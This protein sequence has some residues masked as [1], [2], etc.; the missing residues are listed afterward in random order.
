MFNYADYD[1]D[2]ARVKARFLKEVNKKTTLKDIGELL[3]KLILNEKT[4]GS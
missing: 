1:N 2:R 4:E 3:D